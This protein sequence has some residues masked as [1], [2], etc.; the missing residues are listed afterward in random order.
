MILIIPDK[1]SQVPE[2][3]DEL[4]KMGAPKHLRPKHK[5]TRSSTRRPSSSSIEKKVNTIGTI[6]TGEFRKR[7]PFRFPTVSSYPES[8]SRMKERTTI[9]QE[10]FRRNL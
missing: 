9:Q 4:R 10:R 8:S 3:G 6:P 1:I 7:L 5:G 2:T